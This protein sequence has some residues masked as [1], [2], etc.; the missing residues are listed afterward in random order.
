M[1]SSRTIQLTL[2]PEELALLRSALE[3]LESTVGHE[4]ADE[5]E[6]VKALLARLDHAK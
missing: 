4:E 5:L 6:E 2:T 1:D 3:L